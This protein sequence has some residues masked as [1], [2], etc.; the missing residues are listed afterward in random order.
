[1]PYRKNLTKRWK[2]E[3]RRVVLLDKNG[4]PTLVYESIE[5]AN[6]IHNVSKNTVLR[7]CTDQKLVDNQYWMFADE[8]E[9]LIGVF[10]EDGRNLLPGAMIELK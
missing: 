2:S 1:M 7:R 6:K 8:W 9:D 10:E 5:L 3:K 4:N